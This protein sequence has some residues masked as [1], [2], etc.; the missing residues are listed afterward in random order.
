[1]EPGWRGGLLGVSRDVERSWRA[2]RSSRSQQGKMRWEGFLAI[3]RRY[4]FQRPQ[5]S[6]P[7]TRL[8]QYTVLCIIV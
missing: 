6:L 3:K 1:M 5:L 7:S 2:M 8:K 4:P